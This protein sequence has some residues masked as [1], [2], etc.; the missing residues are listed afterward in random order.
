[1]K[2]AGQGLS[3]VNSPLRP[4]IEHRPV[5]SKASIEDLLRECASEPLQW[6][7]RTQRFGVLL[8]LDGARR[9]AAASGNTLEW[10]GRAPGALL[11]AAAETVLPRRSVDAA[12]AHARVAQERGAAQHLHKVA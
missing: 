12:F 11:G 4:N 9:I 7:G 2:A 1:M 10:C 6:L 8:A 3:Q 5:E